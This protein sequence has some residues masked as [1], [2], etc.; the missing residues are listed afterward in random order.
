MLVNL[1]Y[2]RFPRADMDGL[3]VLV[4]ITK[5][6]FTR[7]FELFTPT[8]PPVITHK[9]GLNEIVYNCLAFELIHKTKAD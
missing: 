4:K 1:Y 3:N 6:E 5:P 8:K 9:N 2:V 7:L